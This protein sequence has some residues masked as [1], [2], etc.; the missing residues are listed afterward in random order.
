VFDEQA[1]TGQNGWRG[2][3]VSVVVVGLNHHAAPLN[4]L[5]RMTVPPA[6]IENALRSLHAHAD[7]DEVVVLSTCNRTEVYAVCETFHGA[8]NA[9][10]RFFADLSGLEIDQFGEYMQ[11][12]FEHGSV[13]HL[14]G[15][16]SGLDSAVVGETEILGQV[17]RAWDMA[18]EAGTCGPNLS[19]L[20]RHSLEAGKRART[21]TAI[22]RGTASVSHA[23]VLLAASTLGGSLVDRSVLVL[24]TG[25]IGVS[26]VTALQ[27][28]GVSDVVVANR[29]RQKAVNL[30]RKLGASYV[31]LDELA[32]TLERVDVLLTATSAVES[33]L[34]VD[35]V[36]AVMAA[37]NGKP[38]LIVDTALP[39]DVE[40][41]VANIEG[42]TL[43]DMV[44]I[45]NF[46]EAGLEER[47]KEIDHVEAIVGEEVVR[48]ET[49]AAAR[50]A[51]PVIRALRTHVETLR[52]TEFDR[53]AA[54]LTPSEAELVDH[55]TR[56]LMAKLLHEPTVAL[57]SHAGTIKG[58][59]IADALRLL[60]D[61]DDV[62][63]EP[64][65]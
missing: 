63:S 23:A 33:V 53:Y 15:V 32:S 18:R 34:H 38:L 11:T 7:I 36:E 64:E 60:F 57:K 30:A 4:V 1:N 24:G 52:Q 59:R 58:Q 31:G 46:V 51:A 5:E 55:A 35:D 8:V 20:F 25:E 26:M 9:I 54:R 48:F 10:H 21:E 28:S 29:T 3:N 2:S 45:R 13:Q 39:R 62:A 56:Q 40:P 65:S 14:F 27:N 41:D 49:D 50:Q 42:V 37:R 44:G 6:G 43:L 16:A 22:A 12:L 47:R 19:G 61:L 17:R